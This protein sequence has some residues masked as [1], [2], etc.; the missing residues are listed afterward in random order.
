MKTARAGRGSS[1]L[2]EL[3]LDRPNI[4]DLVPLCRIAPFHHSLRIERPEI[5]AALLG[6]VI[7]FW[8]KILIVQIYL[9]V[10]RF[11]FSNQ[12]SR[13]AN[14]SDAKVALLGFLGRE[15]WAFFWA[16]KGEE[17]SNLSRYSQEIN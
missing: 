11:A 13:N 15:F 5:F 2:G 1:Y 14:S 10:A 9:L 17:K 4:R 16:T 3:D 7:E 8:T 6:F 12:S